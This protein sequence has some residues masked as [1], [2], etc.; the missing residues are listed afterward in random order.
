MG[1]RVQTGGL[2]AAMPDITINFGRYQGDASVHTRAARLFGAE[3]GGSIAF[4]LEANITETPGAKASD[5]LGL[6]AAGD[7]TMCYFASSYLA[8]QVPEVGVFDVPFLIESR[9]AAYAALDG[10]LGTLLKDRFAA[11]TGYRVLAFWDNGFRHFTNNARPLRTPA[12]CAGLS[13]RSMN[14]ELHQ[15]AFR[16]L[17]FA[18]VFI[19][20]ADYPAAVASGQVDAQENPLT[21]SYQFSVHKFHPY[22]TL[23]G[24]LFGVSLLLCNKQ[25]FDGWPEDARDAV[26]HAAGVATK[27]Q[28]GFAVA[29]D[30]DMMARLAAEGIEPLTLTDAERAAFRDAVQPV[31]DGAR[32]DLGED[33]FRTLS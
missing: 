29:E 6:V 12:D 28:R 19:D 25:I 24:H 9:E 17:G 14:S 16:R 15:S 10:N 23:T 27:A 18:P 1:E 21:N 8:R 2:S 26:I 31:L 13:I 32:A 5:L 11:N 33:I 22:F 30:A 7:L 4:N 20:V 3:L